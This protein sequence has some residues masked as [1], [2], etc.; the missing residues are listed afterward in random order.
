MKILLM[1]GTLALAGCASAP[2][3]TEKSEPTRAAPAAAAA[4]PAPATPA[5]T[6]TATTPA[7]PKSAFMASYKR[8]VRNGTE[9]F[10]DRDAETGS[11]LRKVQRCYTR[12]QLAEVEATTERQMRDMNRGYEQPAQDQPGVNFPY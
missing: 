8:V 9:L 6:A 4:K 2:P 1:V 11:K 12:E 7:Q 5:T 3:T 10:C